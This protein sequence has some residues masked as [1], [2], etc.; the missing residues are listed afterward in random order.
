MAKQNQVAATA[1]Q[2]QAVAQIGGRASLVTK[3][4][5]KYSVD[6]EK[7]LSTLKATAFKTG[8]NTPEVTNEQ[9]MS[10]MIVA[11]QYQLNPFT[12]EIFAFP[13]QKG[14][15]VPVV[16]IDGWL[17]IINERP[18]LESIEF[19][20][21]P[22]ES[23][24]E[25]PAWIACT[26]TRKDRAKPVVVRE[27]FAECKRNTAPWGSHPRRMLRHKALIQSAR[28][29]FGFA[30]IYDPDEAER[31]ATAI[32]VT[33]VRVETKPKTETPRA[34]TDE[35]V[36]PAGPTASDL[37]TELDRAGVRESD[38]LEK[39]DITG[40]DLSAFPAD[41]IPAAIE[42]LRSLNAG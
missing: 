10:L 41:R 15:V 37:A 27:Y 40:T 1:A 21:A 23:P 18:E 42:W 20:Y 5:A 11:D 14:G 8:G 32:D 2:P 38:L 24:E 17:R 28:V 31:I 33:P 4:A 35:V 12:K 6:P 9:L 13:D 39:F 30:G 19:D 29:A 22:T 26:I 7:M 34:R 25:I 3:F 16:S 36:V